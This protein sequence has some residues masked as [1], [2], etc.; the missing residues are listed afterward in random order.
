[1]VIRILTDLSTASGFGRARVHQGERYALNSI[2]NLVDIDSPPPQCIRLENF[3]PLL[4]RQL[5]A[6]TAAVALSAAALPTLHAQTVPTLAAASDLKFAI[7]EVAARFEK[8]S[9]HKLRLVFGSWGNFKTQILQG[10][11]FHLFMSAD[12]NFVY[13]LADAGKTEDRRPGPY[14]CRR[15]HRHHGPARWGSEARWPAQGPGCGAGGWVPEE[16]RDRP[17]RPRALWRAR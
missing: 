12:E 6:W 15:A 3:M 17:L 1:M 8:D 10:A 5:M 11:P 13:E 14:L 4:R 16:V 7:E 9:G 2:S